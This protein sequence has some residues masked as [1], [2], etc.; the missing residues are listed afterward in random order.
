M[1]KVLENSAFKHNP[2]NKKKFRIVGNI[3]FV[4]AISK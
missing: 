4:N 2:I 1:P 3:Y